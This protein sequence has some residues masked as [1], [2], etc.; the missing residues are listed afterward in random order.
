[1]LNS[2][3]R[4]PS[5][6]RL[7]R[8]WIRALDWPVLER[9][10][11]HPVHGAV[12]TRGNFGAA[13]RR[14]DVEA[15]RQIGLQSPVAARRGFARRLLGTDLSA[16]LGSVDLPVLALAGAADR[17][18]PPEESKRLVAL[19]PTAELHVYPGAGHMLPLERTT[20]ITDRIVEFGDRIA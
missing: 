11:S 13:P 1:V 4:G 16:D 12:L 3:A 20:E 15:A 18:V 17:V 19:L 14:T 7:H 9:V 6:D 10:S 2:T 8:A 5:D